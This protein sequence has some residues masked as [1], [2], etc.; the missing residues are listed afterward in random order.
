MYRAI[1]IKEFLPVEGDPQPIALRSQTSFNAPQRI[2][3][4]AYLTGGRLA[5]VPAICE[6]FGGIPGGWTLN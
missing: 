6:E 1:A 3:V 5:K 4:T 2:A